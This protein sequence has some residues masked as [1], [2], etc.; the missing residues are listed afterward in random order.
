MF[1]TIRTLMSLVVLVA[2][3]WWTFTYRIGDSTVAEHLERIGETPEAKGLIDGAKTRI[4]PVLDEAKQ[5]MIGEYIEA[6]TAPDPAQTNRANN[7]VL[8][9]ATVGQ[10]NPQPSPTDDRSAANQEEGDKLEDGS[11][12]SVRAIKPD[13]A[14]PTLA[15]DDAKP[16]P[17]NAADDAKPTLANAADD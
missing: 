16:T 1:R 4:D 13:D 10:P 7:A 12:S 6:P 15:P 5:R 11:D 3:V 17:A 9:T 2:V 14:K 8:V